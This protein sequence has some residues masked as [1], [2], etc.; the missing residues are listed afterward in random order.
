[1]KRYIVLIYDISNVFFPNIKNR[2]IYSFY[3]SKFNELIIRVF[4]RLNLNFLLF[5]KWKK[6]LKDL[7]TII[8]FDTCY[9]SNI[10]K[11]I[12]K[13]N[14]RCKVIFYYWNLINSHYEFVL[15]DPNIDEIWTFDKNDAL[16]YNLKWN[17]QFYTYQVNLNS[18]DLQYD[19]VFLGRDKGRE[20][21]INEVKNSLD[22]LKLNTKLIVIKNESDFLNYNEYLNLIE[23]SKAILDILAPGQIGLTLRTMEA[24]FLKKK[25]IT[26]NHDIKNYDFYNQNNIFIIGEDKQEMLIDF[27]KSDYEVVPQEVVD[28]YDFDNWL[29][30]FFESK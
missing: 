10:S 27:I 21:V 3:N 29:K 15:N 30:R 24:L 16:K 17:P 12:K 28:Y 6:L 1:M 8:I 22:K 26:N 5:G 18:S 4:S 14:K 20:S 9:K 25:L 13:K 11:Y 7:D 23:K 19:V 2:E